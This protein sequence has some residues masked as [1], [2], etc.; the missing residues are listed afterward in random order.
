MVFSCMMQ[1][2]SQNISLN[3]FT[4]FKAA[5]AFHGMRQGAMNEKKSKTLYIKEIT[6]KMSFSS[7][8]MFGKWSWNFLK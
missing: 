2:A 5:H 3:I 1:Y 6:A 7:K 8:G 4:A